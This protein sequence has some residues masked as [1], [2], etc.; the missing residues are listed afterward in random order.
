MH[1]LINSNSF[2]AQRSIFSGVPKAR[3]GVYIYTTVL[4]VFASAAHRRLPTQFS[5]P[6]FDAVSALAHK[7]LERGKSI[8]WGRTCK[9]NVTKRSDAETTI[10]VEVDDGRGERVC[11]DVLS[12]ENG[13]ESSGHAA[14]ET[15]PAKYSLDVEGGD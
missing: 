8:L 10:N 13:V 7:S 14:Y 1:V 12:E 6:R 2:H 5:R 9:P 3:N 4:G 15:V 11:S